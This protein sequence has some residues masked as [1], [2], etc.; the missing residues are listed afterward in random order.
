MSKVI[1]HLLISAYHLIWAH[2]ISSDHVCTQI[3]DRWSP[4][5]ASEGCTYGLAVLGST[6][7]QGFQG[8]NRD[9]TFSEEEGTKVCREYTH[10]RSVRQSSMQPI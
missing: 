9:G 5:L 6:Q 1:S 7:G 4:G 2:L 3:S 10:H 8:L